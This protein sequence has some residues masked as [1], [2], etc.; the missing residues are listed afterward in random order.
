M[1]EMSP[2]AFG[3]KHTHVW[4]LAIE[5]NCI[6]CKPQ[7]VLTGSQAKQGEV[8]WGEKMLSQFQCCFLTICVL[9]AVDSSV[10]NTELYFYQRTEQC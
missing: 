5:M 4:C 6:C 7:P 9:S 1:Q 3:K 10:L 2:T 8:I